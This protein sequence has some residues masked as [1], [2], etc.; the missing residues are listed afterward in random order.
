MER[1][2]KGSCGPRVRTYFLQEPLRERR[3]H[4]SKASEAKK[5]VRPVRPA[6]PF[7]PGTGRYGLI[8][9]GA[10]SVV[11]ADLLAAQADLFAVGSGS[12]ITD[13]L[14]R[15]AGAL[16]L[17]CN[18]SGELAQTRPQLLE[19]DAQL[20]QADALVLLCS[21]ARQDLRK[22]RGHSC[23]RGGLEDRQLDLDAA[24][25]AHASCTV[26]PPHACV[27]VHAQPT[28]SIFEGPKACHA[29]SRVASLREFRTTRPW[30]IMSL[31]PGALTFRPQATLASHSSMWSKALM[32]KLAVAVT[33]FC[34][35]LLLAAGWQLSTRSP[36]SAPTGR[37]KFLILYVA[38]REN[39]ELCDWIR[40]VRE[41]LSQDY[42]CWAVCDEQPAF[43][44]DCN[45]WISDE[46]CQRHNVTHMNLQSTLV[47]A[48]EK[49]FVIAEE[50]G[51]DFTWFLEDDVFVADARLFKNL[52]AA[53]PSADL[54]H[55]PPELIV[56]GPSGTDGWWWDQ[57][58]L[59][60]GGYVFPF[61]WFGSPCKAQVI[62]ASRR[63]LQEARKHFDRGYGQGNMHEYLWYTV[64]HHA[65]LHIQPL[66][67]LLETLFCADL[68]QLPDPS[69]GSRL[70]KGELAFYHAI[71][72]QQKMAAFRAG[73][74]SALPPSAP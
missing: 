54:L 5:L 21:R 41:A 61:P 29:A 10:D 40:S 74:F 43:D 36:T 53:H 65:G 35:V 49:S 18:A 34:L 47:T 8:V 14:L 62:R 3:A 26:P 67:D 27:F 55:A 31:P 68:S 11:R 60:K 72:S 15:T 70:R 6:W 13:G 69:F 46:E 28:S 52:D 42:A 23:P 64:A 71:K 22:R 58:K 59:P 73:D 24:F 7:A 32:N 1:L 16:R 39:R 66:P 50:Y 17:L 45:L 38:R 63:M 19:V 2:L 48:W 25:S 30:H 56:E 57:L 12:G 4:R 20:V 9:D 44:S 37:P 33:L 51:A